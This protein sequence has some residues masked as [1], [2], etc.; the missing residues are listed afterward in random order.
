[1]LF[2]T[3]ALALTLEFTAADVVCEK[4]GVCWESKCCQMN[5]ETK[6]KSND[7]AVDWPRDDTIELLWMTGN[8]GIEYLPVKLP[9]TWLLLG[10]SLRNYANFKEKL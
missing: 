8:R 2:A 7:V 4:I 1:M 9:E 10:G 6:I 3:I 5:L